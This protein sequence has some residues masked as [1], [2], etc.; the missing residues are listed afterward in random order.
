MISEKYTR[1]ELNF[2]DLFA[3]VKFW[4]FKK[5]Y[6]LFKAKKETDSNRISSDANEYAMNCLSRSEVLFKKGLE[7]FEEDICVEKMLRSI[8]KLQAAVAAI[9]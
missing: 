7:V 2:F 3:N 1:R 4:F 8:H 6:K 5:Y 9:V